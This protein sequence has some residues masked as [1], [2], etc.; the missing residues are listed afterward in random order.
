MSKL[1]EVNEQVRGESGAERGGMGGEGEG[2]GPRE[3]R[4]VMEQVRVGGG[5]EGA[6]GRGLGE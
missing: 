2:G 1:I 6:R 4:Q 3:V 5:R